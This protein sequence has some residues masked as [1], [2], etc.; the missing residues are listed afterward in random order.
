[1]WSESFPIEHF[2]AKM[3]SFEMFVL[4]IL[5]NIKLVKFCFHTIYDILVKHQDFHEFPNIMCMYLS[6]LKGANSNRSNNI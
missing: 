6:L 1:M 4:P 5:V 2:W 3:L